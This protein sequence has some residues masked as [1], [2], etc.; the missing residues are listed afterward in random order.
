MVHRD[1]VGDDGEAHG[2]GGAGFSPPRE[3]K[4]AGG[5]SEVSDD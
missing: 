2:P 3:V 5:V 4:G 1:S